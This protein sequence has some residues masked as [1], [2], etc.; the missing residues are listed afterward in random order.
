MYLRVAKAILLFAVAM[1]NHISSA[2]QQE[3]MKID[4]EK[5]T[6]IEFRRF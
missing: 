6:L 3:R 1:N 5:K 2:C 4:E